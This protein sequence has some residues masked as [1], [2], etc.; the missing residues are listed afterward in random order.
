MGLNLWSKNVMWVV[1]WGRGDARCTVDSLPWLGVSSAEAGTKGAASGRGF[2]RWGHCLLFAGGSCWHQCADE[3][4]RPTPCTTHL[5]TAACEHHR[6]GHGLVSSGSAKTIHKT[7]ALT[8]NV[9]EQTPGCSVL[10]CEATSSDLQVHSVRRGILRVLVGHTGGRDVFRT[11]TE[12]DPFTVRAAAPSLMFS[13]H[14]VSGASCLSW[15]HRWQHRR[16]GSAHD[17]SEKETS[18]LEIWPD[19]DAPENHTLKW[20]QTG[21]EQRHPTRP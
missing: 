9:T 18:Q 4:T 14:T 15:R 7:A 2:L 8:G 12:L 11:C 1:C 13:S 6:H 19:K 20:T 16:G 21:S 17:T 3:G 5:N 10:L